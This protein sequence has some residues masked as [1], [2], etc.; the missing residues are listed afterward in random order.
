LSLVVRNLI[1]NAVR[2]NHEGGQVRLRLTEINCKA[3]LTVTDTGLGI[4]ERDRPH[5]FERFYRVDRARARASGGNGLGLAI[6]KSIIEAHG[7]SIGFKSREGKGTEFYV[8][9][10]LQGEMEAKELL[11]NR[12]R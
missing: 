2:Y 5:I 11:A 3:V 1:E 10:P 7:G 8:A 12:E 9:L 6:C 4:R